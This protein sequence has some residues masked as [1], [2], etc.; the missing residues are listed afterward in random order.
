M[1]L[2]RNRST[3]ELRAWWDAVLKAAA[4]A[5]KLTVDKKKSK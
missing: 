3:K 1:K 5:P 2:I 4:S